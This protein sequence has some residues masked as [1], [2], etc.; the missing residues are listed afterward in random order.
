MKTFQTNR[1]NIRGYILRQVLACIAI[2]TILGIYEYFISSKP[3]NWIFYLTMACLTVILFIFELFKKRLFNIQFD[4]EKKQIFFLYKDFFNRESMKVIPF[5]TAR[6]EVNDDTSI[7]RW[8]KKSVTLYFLKNKVEIC[9]VS[10][11]KDGFSYEQ[12]ERLCEL[13][14]SI[15][16]KNN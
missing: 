2:F 12:L 7:F 4:T 1:T 10:N 13:V 9:S 14:K 11:L 15:V 6:I 3:P 16:Q 5:E 8:F